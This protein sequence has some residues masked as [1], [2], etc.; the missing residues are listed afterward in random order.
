MSNDIDNSFPVGIIFADKKN[1]I[2]SI[3]TTAV[4][5]LRVDSSGIIGKKIESIFSSPKNIKAVKKLL[6]STK[7]KNDSFCTI[8]EIVDASKLGNHF[9]K[10]VVISLEHYNQFI[11]EPIYYQESKSKIYYNDL[12]QI[13]RLRTKE[14]EKQNKELIKT[15][16]S[17]EKASH[18]INTEL[19]MAKEIQENILP[20]SFPKI[21]GYSFSHVYTPTGKVGGDFYDIRKLDDENLFILEADV[22]GHGVPA[23]F[24]TAMAKAFF[25]EHI[26]SS[27]VN[28]SEAITKINSALCKN[29]KTEHYITAFAAILHLPTGLLRYC[30]ICH[31]YPAVYR[32]KTKDFEII[33]NNCGFFLGMLEEDNNFVEHSIILEPK[34]KIFIYT[35]GLSEG[36]NNKNKQYGR[37]RLIK[38]FAK[39]GNLA[40]KELLDNIIRERSL[41]T[42]GH[43]ENDDITALIIG[44][45]E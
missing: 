39:N 33:K 6:A 41:F 40:P 9:V 4:L 26:N 17:L 35:D 3:N 32:N 45:E 43:P 31:P 12:E 22:S 25:D 8:I 7:D 28:L 38:S 34:D 21:N 16:H 11:L 44:R 1:N 10:I 24:I 27:T 19:E 20:E 14:I 18:E 5:L 30:R 37:D 42:E 23:A 36:F 13:I 15:K 2:T 29:I